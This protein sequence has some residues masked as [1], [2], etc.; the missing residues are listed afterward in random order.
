MRLAQLSGSHANGSI[1]IA[2]HA[3]NEMLSTLVPAG[4][5]RPIVE[6]HPRNQVTVRYG[7]FSARAELP[8]A[9]ATGHSPTLTLRLASLVVALGLKALVRAPFVHVRGR[10]LT[11]DLARVPALERWRD[12]WRHLRELTFETRPGALCLGVVIDVREED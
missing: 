9:I 7:A 8:H 11:I 5:Q 10:Q 4:R 1:R 6:L 2:E 3:L 12:L